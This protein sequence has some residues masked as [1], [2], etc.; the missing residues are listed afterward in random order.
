MSYVRPILKG[1]FTIAKKILANKLAI[2]AATS[3]ALNLLKLVKTAIAINST[4]R[5]VN[6]SLL[7]EKSF[8]IKCDILRL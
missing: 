2:V 7:Q 5:K 8:H 6:A 1:G 3:G 4:Y